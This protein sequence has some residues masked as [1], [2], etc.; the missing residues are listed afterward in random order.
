MQPTYQSSDLFHEKR[1]RKII[2]ET[3][4]NS[5]RSRFANVTWY[6][7]AVGFI[8]LYVL[9]AID[10]NLSETTTTFLISAIIA[11]LT[12]VAIGISIGH[13]AAH[14][15]ISKRP[16]L[17]RI[18]LFS[19]N[20]VGANGEIWHERHTNGHH[21]YANIPNFDTDIEQSK[22]VRLESSSMHH[23]WH[24]FQ[25]FYLPLLLCFYTLN[26]FFHRDI[27]DLKESLKTSSS[28]IS[29]LKLVSVFVLTKMLH[30]SWFIGLP[31][32]LFD[33][34][35]KVILCGYLL[36]HLSASIM[37]SV[38]LLAAHVGEDQLFPVPDEHGKIGHS[39]FMHQLLTSADFATSN[40]FF[41]WFF[42]GFNHHVAHHLFPE[43]NHIHYPTLTPVIREYLKENGLPYL[44]HRSWNKSILSHYKLL[45]R[46]GDL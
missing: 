42:G 16:V 22:L 32:L 12:T 46:E 34:D 38:V 2:N 10:Y 40:P 4:R 3:L 13:D 15:A 44:E 24:K 39:Y 31:L 28:K 14:N 7:K 43:I 25:V 23:W 9:A 21:P 36:L 18:F 41:N 35:W 26:W 11:G 30:L 29:S 17:N 19:F 20:F 37:V 5:E 1:L 6:L 33:K 27:V 45:I 8:T